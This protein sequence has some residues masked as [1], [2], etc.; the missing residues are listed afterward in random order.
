MSVH[1]GIEKKKQFF[2]KCERLSPPFLKCVICNLLIFLLLGR[3]RSSEIEVVVLAAVNSEKE[4]PNARAHRG[5]HSHTSASVA[6][7]RRWTMKWKLK[8][9][10]LNDSELQNL[11]KIAIYTEIEWTNETRRKIHKTLIAVVEFM[12]RWIASINNYLATNST[13]YSSTLKP[14]P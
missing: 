6:A 3:S 13:N 10:M 14:F 9:L 12:N 11:R 5:E 7:H 1:V 2:C 8:I 4:M